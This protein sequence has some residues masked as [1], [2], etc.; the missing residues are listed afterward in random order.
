LILPVGKAG[1]T[2]LRI[3]LITLRGGLQG[4]FRG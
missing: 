3:L 1:C 4:W 2:S